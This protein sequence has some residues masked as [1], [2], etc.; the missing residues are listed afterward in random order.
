[1]L[2]EVDGGGSDQFH[3]KEVEAQQVEDIQEQARKFLHTRL[4]SDNKHGSAVDLG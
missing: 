1:M 2:N 3:Q 4:N